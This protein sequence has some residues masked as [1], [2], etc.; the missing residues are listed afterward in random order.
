MRKEVEN[1]KSAEKSKNDDAK[2]EIEAQKKV[3]RQRLHE[4]IDDQW[5]GSTLFK[6][7]CNII[8]NIGKGDQKRPT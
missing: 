5:S 4:Y 3:L 7:I 1:L 8:S 2:M 6:I